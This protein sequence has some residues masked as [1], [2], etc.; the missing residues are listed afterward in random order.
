MSTKG[1]FLVRV[2]IMLLLGASTIMLCVAFPNAA[3]NPEAGLV[4]QLPEHISGYVGFPREV[5]EEER[6]WLP[7]DTEML[8]R[9]YQPIGVTNESQTWLRS[10]AVTLIL[11]GSDA[12]SLHRPEVC[13]D[14]Q[15]WDITGH[16]VVTLDVNGKPLPVM[17]LF[18][19][20]TIER[21]NGDLWTLRANY[22]YWWM[23]KEEATPH[24][25]NR[26]LL[27]SMDNVFKNV[28]NRWGYPSV[29]VYTDENET[30][31]RDAA[32][33]RAFYFIENYAHVFLEPYDGEMN[34]R[35]VHAE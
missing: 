33:Q 28:N 5:S 31:G 27:S 30:G 10:I 34:M 2:Q 24:T 11:S 8:K 26:V 21:A 35:L 23:G 12:R 22:L 14:G 9:E 17:D 13:L 3:T 7:W 19:E 15:G 20:R 1:S 16:E 29:M 32:R 18:I 6:Y 4:M 25:W